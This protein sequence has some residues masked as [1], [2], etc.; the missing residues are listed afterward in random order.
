[1]TLRQLEVLYAIMKWGSITAAARSLHVT[2]PAISA[3]L[4]HAEQQLRMKLFERI[5]GK[6]VPTPEATALLPDLEAIFGRIETVGRV[7][8]DLRDGRT[9]NLVIATSATL[10]NALVPPA[11]AALSRASPG[12]NVTI[13]TLT[14]PMAIARVACREADVALVYAPVNDSAVVSEDLLDTGMAVAVPRGHR[15]ARQDSVHVADFGDETI[16]ATGP[17]TR[18]GNLVDDVCHAAGQRAPRIGI[19]ASS[20]MTACIMAS[21]GAGIA[22]V[23]PTIALCGKFDELVFLPFKPAARVRIQLVYPRDRPRSRSCERFAAWLH[24][25]HGAAMAAPGTTPAAA[26][27]AAAGGN[28]RAA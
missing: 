9:G 20:S 2:Q 7:I 24:A 26:A 10:I 15:L 25:R 14:T 21:C 22:L 17:R 27:A 3:V 16:I 11:V 5:A 18:L 19:E 12:L 23:D 28:D 6:L 13:H 4:K 1:M 8:E